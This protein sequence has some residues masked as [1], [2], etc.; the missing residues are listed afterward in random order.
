VVQKSHATFSS[1]LFCSLSE[2]LGCHL[3]TSRLSYPLQLMLPLS[4]IFILSCPVKNKTKTNL[5]YYLSLVPVLVGS[6]DNLPVL[7]V[8]GQSDNWVW[9]SSCQLKTAPYLVDALC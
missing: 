1:S 3:F 4:K 7:F 2:K 6:L 8:I 5:D 9:F